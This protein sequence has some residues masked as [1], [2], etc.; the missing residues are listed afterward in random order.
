MLHLL[1]ALLPF[2]PPATSATSPS[3]FHYYC[4][5]GPTMPEGPAALLLLF[6]FWPLQPSFAAGVLETPCHGDRRTVLDMHAI[7]HSTRLEP[8]KCLF[9][10]SSSSPSS[11]SSSSPSASDNYRQQHRHL[12]PCLIFFLCAYSTF[13]PGLLALGRGIKKNKLKGL[14][15]QFPF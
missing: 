12:N 2:P 9:A 5:R 8:N 15:T 1:L 3:Y 14:K 11:S 4:T 6:L 13:R 7:V 10:S